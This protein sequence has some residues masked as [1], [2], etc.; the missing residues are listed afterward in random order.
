M[1][2]YKEHE[3]SRSGAKIVGFGDRKLK[4][5]RLLGTVVA[6]PLDLGAPVMLGWT[7]L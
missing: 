6:T 5:K 7:L 1:V 3:P 4:Q 2:G